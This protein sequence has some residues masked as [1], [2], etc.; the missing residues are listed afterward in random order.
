[1]ESFLAV[2]LMVIIGAGVVVAGVA[3]FAVF[4]ILFRII[5]EIA[6]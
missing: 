4:W 6:L 5:I 2:M 1:M 3:L